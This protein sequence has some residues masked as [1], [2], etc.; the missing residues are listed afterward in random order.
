MNLAAQL[1]ALR[2]DLRGLTRIERAKLCCRVAKHFEKA[3]EYEAARQA[4][5][6][7]WPQT[8]EAPNFNDLDKPTAAELLLRIGALTGWLGSTAQAEGSQEGAKNLI[9]TSIEIFEELGKTERAA[10]ARSDLALCYWRE[11]SY[12]EARI[13]M[14]DALTGLGNDDSDLRA[15]VL[16]RA[17]I[18]EVWSQR[19]NEALRF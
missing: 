12:D 18:V 19:L 10:E 6:E 17:G 16:I 15:I 13:H 4:L 11:G 1:T 3:G 8:V 14:A 5:N 7:F 2:E 9:T